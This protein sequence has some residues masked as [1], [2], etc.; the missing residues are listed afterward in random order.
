MSN[1]LSSKPLVKPLKGGSISSNTGIF[2]SINANSLQLESISIAGLFEDGILL[3][4]IMQDSEL[5]NTVIG[6]D[7]PNIGYFTSLTT[8]SDVTFLSNIPG[9]AVSW[10]PNTGLFYI[11]S[12]FKV[13][14]CSVLGNIEICNNDISSVNLNGEINMKPN[15]IAP[16][17]VWAPFYQSTSNGNFY[18]EVTNGGV[19]FNAKNDIGLTTSSGSVNISSF[20]GQ[21]L[22]TLNGDIVLAT[23]LG[24]GTK[25]ISKVFSTTGNIV[26]TTLTNHNLVSGNVIN[27]SSGVL[28]GNFTVGSVLNN[29]NFFLTTTT[30]SMSL[31]SGTGG[32]LYKPQTNNI[33]LNTPALVK[34][35]TNSKLTL[36]D[37]ANNVYGNTGGLFVQS[38]GDVSFSIGNNSALRIPQGTSVVF[39]TSGNAVNAV[40]FDGTN[41]NVAGSNKIQLT[42]SVTQINSTNT[43]FYD[44]I[45]TLADYPNPTNDGKDRGVEFNYFDPVFGTSKLGWFGYKNSTGKFTFI[46]NA[47][48]NNETI[49]GSIGSLE[50][51]NLNLNQINIA[52]GGIIDMGCGKMLNVNLITGCGNTLTIAGSTNVTVNATSRIALSSGT[53][54]LIPNSV[55]LKFSTSGSYIVENSGGNVVFASGKNT[56]ILSNVVSVPVASVLSF[57]GTSRGSQRMSSNTSGDLIVYSDSNVYLT[58]TGGNV[59]LPFNTSIYLGSSSGTLTGSAGVVNLVSRNGSI[60]VA[61]S[62]DA[63][64]NSSSGNVTLKASS[65]D[66]SLAPSG[67]VKIAQNIPLTFGTTE[68]SGTF[69]LTTAGTLLFTGNTYASFSLTSL[70]SI[71][72][73]ASSAINVP[74]STRLYIG[75][76]GSRYIYSDT[77]G[78]MYMM[79]SGTSGGIVIN[80]LTSTTLLNTG[81]SLNIN[82]S[83]TAV[84][85]GA[86]TITGT[87]GS[88]FGVY[89]DNVSMKDPVVMIGDQVLAS[90]D[91][92]DRGI[93]YRYYST[94]GT[95]MNLGWFGYKNSTGRFTFYSSATNSNEVITGAIGDIEINNGY[96][97]GG[98]SF[99]NGGLIDLNCGTMTN[100]RT[101][102]GCGGM[103]DINASTQATINTGTLSLNATTG[104]LCPYNVP[105]MFGA[106]SN[107][108]SCDTSGTLYIN[109]GSNVVIN[110]N[111]QINGTTT[112]VYSTV[113][114]LQDPIFSLGGVTG[115][116]VNDGKDRGV[117]FKWNNG[118]QTKTGF[119]GYKN[120]LGRFVFIGDG[121]NNNE[122]FSGAYGDI[123]LGSIYLSNGNISGVAGLSGGVV[124][125]STTAGNLALTP[126]SGSSIMVPYNTKIGFGN[127]ANGIG[128]DTGGNLYVVSGNDT[129]ISAGGK[130][131]LTA[132]TAGVVIPANVPLNMGNTTIV[133]DTSGN[134][135]LNASSGNINLKPGVGTTGSVNIPLNNYL[136]F[137]S[138]ANSI[139]SDGQQLVLNG[140]DVIKLASSVNILGNFNVTGTFTS[141]ATDVNLNKYILPLGTS[142]I[143]NITSLQS[144]GG[145]SVGNVLV[146]T[147]SAGNLS[148]G[149]PV[150]LKNTG[151][152]VDGSYSVYSVVSPTSFTITANVANTNATIGTVQTILT[153][154]QGKDVGIEVDYWSTTGNTNITAGSAGYKT[155]FFGFKRSTERWSF[156]S[157][158]TIS[159]NVVTGA[160]GDIQVNQVFASKLSGVVMDGGISAGSYMV[161][162]TNFQIS[163]GNINN[164]PIGGN[165]AA[166]G[167]FTTLSNTVQAQLASVAL[168]SNLSYSVERYALNSVTLPTRSPSA[169][170][171]VSLF[172]VSGVNFISASGTM[173]TTG[174]ADGTLK[175]I[176]CSTVDQGAM[177]TLHFGAGKLVAPNPNGGV[178][179]KL[180]FKRQS[181]S[182]QLMYDAVVGTWILLNSGC[183]VG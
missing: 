93:Q 128:S 23:E 58:T 163:G 62:G 75:T 136:N 179:T 51:T 140:V 55:P 5:R 120:A 28:S 29:T 35:P 135:N 108:F 64:L 133:S 4:V 147:V 171:V 114:N 11:T 85:V 92:K 45:L 8:Y 159:N 68:N 78:S 116:L 158:A 137:G 87:A 48:N 1:L 155:G 50:L 144:V 34:I 160:Y 40:N 121:T 156:Y 172:S 141:T 99:V 117:E 154:E 31:W 27:I 49:S 146:T 81:G 74:N 180:I 174:V 105:V 181:Q 130:I 126:T 15:G 118:I 91:G 100:T 165:V 132:S 143:L 7:G 138:T 24:G 115:P 16:L 95:A 26:V 71:D 109:A 152:S 36:G 53:D 112:N 102:V 19:T 149:D 89:T 46:T 38:Q 41:L 166:T 83:T 65:G 72:L 111:V 56:Q 134:M 178:A 67:A 79:N 18:S 25:G 142:Q 103:L 30:G 101:I 39:G 73:L 9:A 43:R 153:T 82:N 113:T 119:F 167:R 169:G 6:V 125:I 86:M 127:T 177:Y 96:L 97:R 59:I 151:T 175:V 57:D 54:V 70:A 37:T 182:A 17:N 76:G 161:S 61:S 60:N 98:L 150:T 183:Y 80:A 14:G 104:I 106:S 32:T 94:A 13:G 131:S 124:T 168:Q 88:S 173:P 66:V 139:Y 148:T 63:T 47:T 122:V 170:Y 20:G 123:Q 129:S 90:N 145:T 176:V 42:G 22:S 21:A 107:S 157:N 2:N 44:P 10:D 84:S 77:V 33:V 164:T 69:M 12:K 110:S 162:G 52:A 3:N